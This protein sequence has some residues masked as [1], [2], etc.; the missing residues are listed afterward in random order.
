MAACSS[1]QSPASP[2]PTLK[3]VD[4]A[5]SSAANAASNAS[6]APSE[7]ASAPVVVAAEAASAPFEPQRSPRKNGDD[8]AQ[9]PDAKAL[10]MSLSQAHD[11]PSDWVWA[12]L[13][14]ARYR[15]VVT[16]L[17]MPAASSTTKNWAVYKSRFVEPIRIRAGQ[18]F[19]KTY[20]HEL[21]R[22]EKTYGV[23]ASIIAGVL[24]VETIYGRQ[25]G[26]FR[27]LD[28][29]A[30]LSL[31]FPSGRSDRS[32][33]FKRE[34][35]EFLKL[36]HEQ[37]LEPTSVLGSYAGAIGW[38]QF[39]PSSIR[40]HAV[41]FDGDGRIDLQRSPIDAI[42][43]VAKFLADHGWRT[44]IQTYFDVTAPTDADALNQLLAPDIQPTFTAAQMKALGTVLPPD[45]DLNP[46]PL[47]LVQLLN[48]TQAPTL[49]VGTHNFYVITRYNQS[50]YYALAVIELGRAVSLP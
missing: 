47:A 30:T 5:A 24:G 17:I 25:M 20:A 1:P 41:D 26:N 15:D 12:Q 14:Q 37:K 50:S 46:G 32:A 11:L 36:C 4:T 42:G 21:A 33:F 38:P 45:A 34:L 2:D 35:G 44:G 7:A 29:L 10:A 19:V 16:K 28:A 18:A 31:N 39:M 48:G 8:Y 23:P 9:R 3:P 27:V 49:I 22:A 6:L 40:R 13:S 43:S